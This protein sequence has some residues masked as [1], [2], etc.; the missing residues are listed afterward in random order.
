M[1]KLFPFFILLVL[2]LCSCN[3]ALTTKDITKGKVTKLE[4]MEMISFS[5]VTNSNGVSYTW[6]LSTNG[7][8]YLTVNDPPEC[9]KTTA[10]NVETWT[11]NG[12][13]VLTFNT[14]TKEVNPSFDA[15]IH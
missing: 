9:V 10:G 3:L 5:N 7:F 15:T 13:T 14:T 6:Q 12:Q 4:N 8:D 2:M 1:K 11:C